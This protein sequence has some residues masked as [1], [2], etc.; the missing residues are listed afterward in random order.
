MPVVVTLNFKM[1]F[2][3]KLLSGTAT[4]WNG[5]QPSPVLAERF[6]DQI[7]SDMVSISIKLFLKKK[8]PF[9]VTWILDFENSNN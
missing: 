4:G 1:A 2:Y 7:S 8:S 3:W 9:A 6:S 5:F